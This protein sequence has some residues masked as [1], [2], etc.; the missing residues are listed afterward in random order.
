MLPP[1]HWC[2]TR[3]ALEVAQ[4]L[5]RGTADDDIGIWHPAQAPVNVALC[6]PARQIDNVREDTHLL[7][8][9]GRAFRVDHSINPL[10]DSWPVVTS[11][12]LMKHELWIGSRDCLHHE[13][14]TL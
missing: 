11:K 5:A 14:G 6:C 8:A 10:P 9:R 1:E 2:A 4:V 3:L 12:N 7:L 13:T